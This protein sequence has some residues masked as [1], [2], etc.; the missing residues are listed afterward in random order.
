M[1]I[2]C[3]R[4]EYELKDGDRLLDNGACLQFIPKDNS[5]L[6]F[7]MWS[8]ASTAIMSKKEFARIISMPNITLFIKEETLK[9]YIWHESI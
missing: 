6:P 4:H 7:K 1:K 5:I 9:Y 8:R 3:G 2:K